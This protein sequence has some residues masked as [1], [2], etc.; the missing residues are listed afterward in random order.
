MDVQFIY[1][2]VEGHLYYFQDLVAVTKASIAVHISTFLC[3][4]VS[5]HFSC[6][7]I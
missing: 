7:N 3:A 2:L 6:I 1:P 4:N 5:F